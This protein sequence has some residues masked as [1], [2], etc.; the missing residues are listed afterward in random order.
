MAST[1][2]SRLD[3]D[4]YGVPQFSGDLEMLEEYM[5]RAWGVL[6]ER[7]AGCASGGDAIAPEGPTVR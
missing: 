2:D 3:T 6:W 4:R 1:T 7:R 5:D